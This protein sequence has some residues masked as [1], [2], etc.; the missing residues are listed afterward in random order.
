MS[1]AQ[2][3]AR[4]SIASKKHRKEA[5]I[6]LREFERRLTDLAR[7]FDLEQRAPLE[8]DVATIEKLRSQL[9]SSLFDLKAEQ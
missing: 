4:E 5:E 7:L 1:Y 3:G 9:L 6:S 2:R 8:A